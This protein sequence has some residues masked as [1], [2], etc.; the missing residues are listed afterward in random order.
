M[1]S[2]NHLSI[3]NVRMLGTL[4]LMIDGCQDTVVPTEVE[5]PISAVIGVLSERIVVL[6]GGEVVGQDGEIAVA[7]NFVAV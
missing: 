4:L 1:R 2:L 7:G 3:R 5:D 6:D